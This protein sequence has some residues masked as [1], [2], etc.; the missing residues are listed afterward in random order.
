ML[1]AFSIAPVGAGESVSAEVAEVIRLVRESG[2][3]N[4]TN[5]MFTNVE[6]E[7]DEVM[8]LVKACTEKLAETSPRVSLVMKVD[9]RP[10]VEDA[11]HSK[12]ERI[13]QRLSRA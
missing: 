3:P 6:G 9:Y 1:L 5:A 13:E 2:L 7:W 11:M 8:A 4:E 10:G 12:V